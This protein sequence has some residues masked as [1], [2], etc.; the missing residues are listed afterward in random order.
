MILF[1]SLEA[2]REV[3]I[4]RRIGKEKRVVWIFIRLR[5]EKLGEGSE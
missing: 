2:M 4:E 3:N 1:E 5:I